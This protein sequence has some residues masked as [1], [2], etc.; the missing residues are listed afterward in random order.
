MKIKVR[1][2]DEHSMFSNMM[3][4]MSLLFKAS[5]LL[6]IGELIWGVMNNLP[7]TLILSLIHI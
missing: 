5:P 7:S 2:K 1:Q 4:F 3:F 6:V